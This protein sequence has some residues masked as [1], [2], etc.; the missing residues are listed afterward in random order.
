MIEWEPIPVGYRATEAGYLNAVVIPVKPG[1][2]NGH[3]KWLVDHLRYGQEFAR[4]ITEAREKAM[5]PI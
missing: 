4:N 1:S 3:S 2:H 5:R